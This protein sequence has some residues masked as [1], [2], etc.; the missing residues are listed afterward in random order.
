MKRLA[1]AALA[2]AAL[3]L[4]SSALAGDV[5]KVGAS[6]V[7]HAEILRMAAPGLAR[8]G[9]ELKVIEFNDYVQPNLALA[10]RSLD[11]NFFQ[12]APHLESFSRGRGLRLA[13]LC[14]VHIE[15]MGVYSS[16]LKSLAELGRK[17]RVAIPNDP[18]NGGRALRLL[19]DAGLIKLRE[20]AGAGATPRDIV[21]NPRRLRIVEL[22]AAALPRALGDAAAAVINANYALAAGLDPARDALAR[23]SGDSPYANVVAVREGDG[24]EALGKLAEALRSPAVRDFLESRYKGA[25]LPAF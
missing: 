3:A 20:G 23:E 14:A 12:H 1:A 22:E 13:A 18:A 16:R 2:C 8:Q 24:R 9:V 15:P 7:P 21:G 6:P 5:L 19:A 25:V 17:D 10:D 4:S 11:A